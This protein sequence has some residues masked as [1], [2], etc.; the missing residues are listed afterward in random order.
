MDRLRVAMIGAGAMARLHLD[1][2]QSLEDVEV[3]AISSRGIE[4]L[5]KLAKDCGI[6]QRFRN[7]DEMLETVKP[8]AVVVTVNAAN[9]YDV[10][11]TCIKHRVSGLIEKPPGLNAAQTEGLLKTSRGVEG[12]YM[13]G[14]NRRFYSVIQNAKKLVDDSGGLVSI[15]VH[16]TEDI[17][18]VRAAEFHPPEVLERWLAANGVHCIDLL[19]FLGGEV[20]SVHALSSAWHDTSRNSFGALIRHNGGAI[21]HFISNWTAPGRWEVT[22]YGFDM[23]VDISPLEEAKLIRRG[24]SIFTVPRDDVDARFK[25]GLY[26]QDKYFVEHV[27]AK[28]PIERPAANLEDA[29][30]TMRLVEAIA[31]SQ[32]D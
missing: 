10:A 29:L 32:I 26:A 16:H 28:A 21:G 27:K 31:F 18:A 17:A 2:L 14:L 22:L 11:L 30:D 3:V 7:N 13:V 5:E 8:D 19:R 15:V 24:G 9:V 23:R 1:V 4:R 12:Q 20:V 25:P 6:C